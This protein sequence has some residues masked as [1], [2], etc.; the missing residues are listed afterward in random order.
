VFLGA[1]AI[2]LLAIGV[3]AFSRRD[4]GSTSTL[5]APSMPRSLLGLSGPIARATSLNLVPAL[6]WGAGVGLFG[7][8]FGGAAGQFMEQLNDSPQFLELLETAFPG[9]DYASAGGFL[10]L[11][12]VELGVILAGLAVATF[13]SG[14]ASD[15]NSG[16]LEML[17]A[18][19][20]ERVRWAL[21]SGIGMLVNVA[22]FTALAAAG[23]AIGVTTSGG[24]IRTPVVGSLILA[25]YGVALVGIGMTIG[26]VFGA[27]FAGSFVVAFVLVTWFVQIVGGLLGLPDVVLQLALTSHF[28]QTF[29]G[30]WDGVGVIASL[31]L[32]VGGAAIGAL[33]FARRDLRG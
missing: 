24:D 31:L 29:V 16:R 7:L 8:V 12:F 4:I 13:V 17:L 2:V 18:T 15:E 23:I 14:W 11:L 20:R 21:A 3:E 19:P 9:I 1:A 30:V 5:L 28:G 26:G 22:I 33:A 25:V 27:R 6:A 32:G 10:Q